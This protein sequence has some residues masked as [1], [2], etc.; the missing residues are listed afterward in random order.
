MRA[1]GYTCDGCGKFSAMAEP[2][3]GMRPDYPTNWRSVTLVQR[4]SKGDYADADLCYCP[5]CKP[6]IDALM[7]TAQAAY[8]ERRRRFP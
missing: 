2:V 3:G 7:K 6:D 5:D 1:I 8:D 4:T